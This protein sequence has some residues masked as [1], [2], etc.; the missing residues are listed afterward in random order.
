MSKQFKV[1]SESSCSFST[2]DMTDSFCSY[3][4]SGLIGECENCQEPINHDDGFFCAKCGTVIKIKPASQSIYKTRK[5]M[6]L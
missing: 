3:C 2:D 5:A 1:C 6:V 4:G